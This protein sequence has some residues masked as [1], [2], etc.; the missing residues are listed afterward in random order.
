MPAKRRAEA[1]ILLAEAEENHLGEKTMNARWVRWHTCGLCEQRYHGVVCCALGWACWKT[2]VGRPEADCVRRLSMNVLGSGLSAAC[3]HEDALC[4]K[5]ADLALKRRFGAPEHSI[6]ETQGNLANTYA[7]LGRLEA[8]S[9]GRDVYLGNVKLHGEESKNALIEV[10]NYGSTLLKFQ[11]YGEAKPL[12]RKNIPVARRVLGEGDETTLKMRLGYAVA[13][14][15]DPNATL[16]DLR[17]AVETLDEAKRTARR[18]LGVAHPLV[19]L[20]ESYLRDSRAALRVRE[21]ARGSDI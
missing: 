17:E 11:C 7:L 13:L 14:Y 6:L 4:V 1:K 12:M 20:A 19:G 2:Y 5:E 15:T 10:S 8:L 9:M 16:D 3:L 18:V 21:T